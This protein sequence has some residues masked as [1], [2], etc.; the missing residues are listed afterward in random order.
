MAVFFVFMDIFALTTGP[1]GINTW[2]VGLCENKVL[3]FDPAA[4]HFT[5]DSQ[6]IVGFLKEKNL[7]PVAFLLTHGHFDHITGTGVCKSFYPD[8]PLAVHKADSV[9]IGKNAA[10]VQKLQLKGMG[11][12]KLLPALEGLPDPDVVFSGEEILSS[13]I[14]TDDSKVKDALS[15]WKIF[16]TPGHTKGSVCYYNE[17]EKIL[18]TGDTIFYHSWGRT[19]FPGGSESEMNKSLGRI[20]STLPHDVLVYPGHEYAGFPLGENL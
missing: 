16:N 8:V 13:I 3:V 12:E 15:G 4:C 14:K 10:D 7:E 2:I 20:Y 19:D 17:K 11:L 6:K 5:R 1:F 9:M 18:I